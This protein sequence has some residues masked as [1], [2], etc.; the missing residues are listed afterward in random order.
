MRGDRAQALRGTLDVW[1]KTA[2]PLDVYPDTGRSDH[3]RRVNPLLGVFN[4]HVAFTRI[5]IIETGVHAH[6]NVDDV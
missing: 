6:R 2:R 1:L 4:A 3:Y 5:W